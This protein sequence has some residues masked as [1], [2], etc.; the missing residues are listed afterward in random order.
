[1]YILHSRRKHS[2]SLIVVAVLLVTLGV[3]AYMSRDLL[4]T[5][6]VI[7]PQ[8]AAVYSTV[9]DNRPKPKQ[10]DDKLYSFS[11]PGDWEKF[12][13]TDALAGSQSWRNTKDN[14]GVRV[15]T[16]YT[17]ADLRTMAVNRALPVEAAID[18]FQLQG[19]VSDNCVS[20]TNQQP[21]NGQ[22]RV[23]AKWE[24]TDFI[25]DTANRFRNV[26][27]ISGN[28]SPLGLPLSGATSGKHSIFITYTDS[29]VNFN[30]YDFTNMIKSF[31]MK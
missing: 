14:K 23:A 25:C 10:F 12:T 21:D 15:I 18:R 9:T 4:D 13:M 7:G 17:D 5:E 24:G 26:V 19:D 3:G 8:P 22:G 27:G 28:A 1:M 20:F 11:L 6:T 16:I 2:R 29:T 31:R 30:A